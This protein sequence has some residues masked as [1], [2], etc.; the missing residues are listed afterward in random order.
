MAEGLFRHLVRDRDDFEVLSAGVGASRGQPVSLHTAEVLRPWGIDLSRFRSQPIT[1]ELVEKADFIFAMTRGH[2]DTIH[3]LFPEAADKAFLVCEFDEQ[4]ARYSLDI[5]DPI[6]QG[7]SAYFECRDVLRKALPTLLTFI[8]EASAH[9]AM[10]PTSATSTKPLRIALG[11]D[12]GGFELKRNVQSFLTEKGFAV[13]DLGT[14]S[15]ESTDYSDFAEPVC[16]G[17]V[18]GEYDY[19]IL[20]CKSG[21][22]MSIAANRH[23]HIRASLVSREEDA[24]VTRQHNNSNVLCLAAKDVSAEQAR[25]IVDAYLGTAFEGGRHQR[26]ID[27]LDEISSDT[28]GS[29]LAA[30]DPEIAAAIKA[31]ETRQRENIELIASEN[32]VS[33]AVMEAQGSVLTNK[34]AEGYPG[35][36]WYGGCEH[37]D[38]VEA[39]AHGARETT[40]PRR[41]ARQRPAALR[42]AGK[43]GGLFFR[44]PAGRQNPDDGPLPRRP[45]HARK[46]GKFLRPILRGLALRR[47]SG[48]RAD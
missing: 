46:Q 10:T 22:G 26:R 4:L 7:V 45:S 8:D 33:R 32:F 15:D 3:M 31:E 27:K 11:A 24:R 36:R 41:G 12:H 13:S 9:P 43:H 37:V 38:V 25:K 5:P 14:F 28:G 47:E 42:L 48:R 30:V 16:R 17:V 2:L 35:K 19:G 39:L 44:P 21:I 40:F 20:F 34:Y 1:D 23:P 29:S 6:G 18:S